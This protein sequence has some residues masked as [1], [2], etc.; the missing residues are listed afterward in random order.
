MK[1]NLAS[2][3][4]VVGIICLLTLFL[5]LQYRWIG[6]AGEAER[7][8]MQR[9]VEADANAFAIDFNR[10]IQAAYFNFQTD[11]KALEA[12]DF[13]DFNE[14]YDFWTNRTSY[15][16]LISDILYLPADA[17]AMPMRYEAASR[18]FVT[19]EDTEELAHIRSEIDLRR[20]RP[21]IPEM[22]LLVLPMHH[23]KIRVQEL[24]LE[25]V[26]RGT[27]AS[28]VG[29]RR[30]EMPQPQGNLI[31]KL[32]RAVLRERFLRDLEEKHFPGGEFIVSVADR[33]GEIIFGDVA[34]GGERD[35]SA[36]LYD[37]TPDS[38]IFFGAGETPSPKISVS[39]DSGVVVSR[40]LESSAVGQTQKDKG[41]QV[42]SFSFELRNT[43]GGRSRTAIVTSSAD[44][45]KPWQLNVRHVSG[46]IDSYIA[47]ERRKSLA[48]GTIVYLFLVGS[49][50]AV[51]FSANRVRRFAQRQ[52]D[53]VS[54][55][56]HEFRTPLAVIYS[57]GENLAD[58]VA[59]D[60]GQVARYGEVIKDEGKKLSAMVEQILE[61][62]GARSGKRKYN[63]E[64]VSVEEQID[65]AVKECEPILSDRGVDPVVAVPA[66]LPVVNAD[67]AALSL[68]IQNLINN[69]VKYSDR[70]AAISI[71]AEKRNGSLHI[72]VEDDGIGISRPD[73]KHI[74]EPFYRSKAV[75][76]AQ[77]HGSG[78]GLSLVKD[79]AEAHGGTVHAESVEGKGSKFTIELPI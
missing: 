27:A 1:G 7:E 42:G 18:A 65:R 59:A 38:M 26:S 8:R 6:E 39:R 40:S 54:S 47:G 62:A 51:V 69:A 79:I 56:S 44:N 10:E 28:R 50:L 24:M 25:N 46:S 20:P 76:D 73:L 49:I 36:P 60:G 45:A 78:L 77:I 63:F 13:T 71:S 75:V 66:N 55:V 17:N 58:G 31:V 41:E 64:P 16:G 33:E 9:R 30:M 61:F 67:R 70:N 48:I 52:V 35:A 3:L 68:A 43:E 23:A 29:E 14:R 11:A 5:L 32:D 19:I 37:L 53:F 22:D 4:I 57:A 12:N 72:S 34:A 15:P 74:F 2:N 21:V